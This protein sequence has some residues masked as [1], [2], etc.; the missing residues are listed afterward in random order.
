MATGGRPAAEEDA[1]IAQFRPAP[2]TCA[3]YADLGCTA[4]HARN[5]FAAIRAGQEGW[6]HSYAT[7]LAYCP[8]HVPAWV[9]AW[10]ARKAAR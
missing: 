7:D 5:K 1:E 10:R 4:Q 2:V 9:A 3:R 8:L 6:F